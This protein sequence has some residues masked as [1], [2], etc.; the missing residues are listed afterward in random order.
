MLGGSSCGRSTEKSKAEH[1][2]EKSE[3]ELNLMEKE[4]IEEE[5]SFEEERFEEEAEA[6]GEEKGGLEAPEGDWGDENENPDI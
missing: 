2:T 6:P 1:A 4:V 3:E 5:K